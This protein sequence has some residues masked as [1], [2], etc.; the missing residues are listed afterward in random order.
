M[1]DYIKY[2]KYIAENVDNLI[3]YN[4]YIANNLDKTINYSDYI[5]SSLMSDIDYKLIERRNKIRK[6][7]NKFEKL[8]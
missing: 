4:D 5:A 3:N 2:N 6:I 7:K 1:G 8:K